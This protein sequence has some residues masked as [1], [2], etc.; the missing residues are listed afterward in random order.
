MTVV[1]L[2]CGYL[3]RCFKI[4]M[5]RT[6]KF[7]KDEI[8]VLSKSSYVKNIRENRLSFIY[9]FRCILYD[10]WIKD[11]SITQIR[12]CLELYAFDYT[13]IGYNVLRDII[14]NFKR[15]GRPS[16]GKNSVFGIPNSLTERH[17][18]GFLIKSGIFIKSRN[19]IRFIS[20]FIDNVYKELFYKN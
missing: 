13:M 5:S 8:D 16:G 12:K 7:T 1:I 20:E 14:K 11:L 6:K 4:N 2:T 9:E 19:G 18:N 10:A 3:F 15:D 17:D